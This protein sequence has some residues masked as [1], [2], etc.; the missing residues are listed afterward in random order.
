[1]KSVPENSRNLRDSARR[2]A[3]LV[4]VIAGHLGASIVL[5][6]PAVF[7]RSPRLV[8][9]DP[10]MLKLRFLPRP[11]TPTHPTSRP[12][13]ATLQSQTMTP[14]RPLSKPRAVQRPARP[15]VQTEEFPS[16][17][18]H[19]SG[20]GDDFPDDGGFHARLRRAQRAYDVRGLPGFHTSL[21]PGIR[22]VDP[23]DQGLGAV[24]RTAQRALGIRSSHCIDVDVR[25]QLTPE[26]LSTRHL[27]PG[28]VD[29]ADEKYDCN[30]PPGL[31]F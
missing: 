4:V 18:L 1:M 12:V 28:D 2:I 16:L 7:H 23:M 11:P 9:N 19:P 14:A 29:K 22:L 24:M 25:R 17:A 26:E 15:D 3:I 5:L 10:R 20:S 13:V 30:R 27:S 6:Q 31:H 21:V 8:R